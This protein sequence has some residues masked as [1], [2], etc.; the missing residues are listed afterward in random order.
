VAKE[1]PIKGIMNQL[2]F[3][4]LRC[5][6]FETESHCHHPAQ[7]TARADQDGG[8]PFSFF[9]KTEFSTNQR[10]LL[11]SPGA[12]SFYP[13]ATCWLADSAVGVAPLSL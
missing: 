3:R 5:I 1:T 13:S 2:R 4:F 9:F 12:A 8:L 6:V 11:L 7:L 10:P